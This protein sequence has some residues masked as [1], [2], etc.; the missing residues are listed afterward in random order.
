MSYLSELR[1]AKCP[2]ESRLFFCSPFSPSEFFV[3]TFG[4]SSSTAP[5]A[6]KAAYPMLKHLPRSGMDLLLHIFGLS[7]TLHSFPYVWRTSIIPIYEME[8][9][10]GSLA[11]FQS[12]SFASCVS[13]LFERI[14]LSCLLFFL[15]S[16]FLSLSPPSRFPPWTVCSESN[17]VSLSV[18]L[19]WV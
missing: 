6:G 9:P 5:G 1:R 10:L 2:G 13:R 8:K 18:H 12:I 17:F 15:E 16:G 7:W 3:V 4:L 11:S 19:G 14:V